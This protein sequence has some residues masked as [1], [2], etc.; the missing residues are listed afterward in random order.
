MKEKHKDMVTDNV[1]VRDRAKA[2][3]L[4]MSEQPFTCALADH[5]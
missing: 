5:R 4:F 1:V 3:A 2:E